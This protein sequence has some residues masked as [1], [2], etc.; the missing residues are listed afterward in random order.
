MTRRFSNRKVLVYL[1]VEE[2]G[3]FLEKGEAP[4]DTIENVNKHKCSE[5]NLELL[6]ALTKVDF[7]RAV[8]QDIMLGIYVF[9]P[10]EEEG[11]KSKENE[12]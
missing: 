2:V 11:R 6:K 5:I 1:Q 3:D 12:P 8:D 9:R 10:H 4:N 7:C